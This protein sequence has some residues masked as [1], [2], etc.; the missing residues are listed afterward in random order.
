[1]KKYYFIICALFFLGCDREEITPRT[2]PQFSVAFI[3]EID[4]V[5]AEFSANVFDYGSDEIV[6]YGF[7]YGR[8]ESPRVEHSEVLKQAGKPEKT[9]TM[10][11]VHSLVIG[12]KYF[13]AAFIRTSSSVIYSKSESFMSKGSTG[14]YL[15]RIEH[16]DKLY[17]GDTLTFYGSNFSRVSSSYNIS[18]QG[19]KMNVFNLK[20]DVFQVKL[21]EMFP[22]PATDIKEFKLKVEIAGKLLELSKIF[23]FKD[24]II[25]D[26]EYLINY[27][28]TVVIR[29]KNLRSA[30]VSIHSNKT[31]LPLIKASDEE[32]VFIPKFPINSTSNSLMVNIR[33]RDILLNNKLKFKPT[34]VN[35]G[36]IFTILLG[37]TITLNGDNFNSFYPTLHRLSS[38]DGKVNFNG[39]KGDQHQTIKFNINQYLPLPRH[40]V[41]NIQTMGSM[42]NNTIE[43][44]LI[45]PALKHFEAWPFL[46]LHPWPPGD[47]MVSYKGVGL[48][49]RR[50]RIFRIDPNSKKMEFLLET[51]NDFSMNKIALAM[52]NKKIFLGQE[53]SDGGGRYYIYDP[54]MNVVVKEGFL[55][56]NSPFVAA[57]FA[58]DKYIY[59]QDIESSN[60]ENPTAHRYN[61]Q[62]GQW[63]VIGT[64]IDLSINQFRP[65]YY[66]NELYALCQNTGGNTEIKRFDQVSEKWIIVKSFPFPL[67]VNTPEVFIIEGYIYATTPTANIRISL[68]DYRLETTTNIGGVRDNSSFSIISG[69]KYYVLHP[70]EWFYEYD[71]LYFKF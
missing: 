70:D 42:A 66:Q 33:G 2:N 8:T 51:S 59:C 44:N 50:N 46:R 64:Y 6:E 45:N 61:I 67:D 20:E 24:P 40:V 23:E 37:E 69:G 19:T 12:Q 11:A 56:N 52:P 13:V 3:Q 58:T 17:F 34:S 26:E 32:I 28:D 39:L 65:Y 60:K 9:F 27:S 43:I 14:F 35:G 25:D 10:K 29:G 38:L 54:E 49:F 5:G 16:S 71:P 55:P 36:Q 68:T 1:M 21:P 31:L 53:I 47:K 15:E 63:E 22:V 4:A 48:F 7:V 62:T 57:A 41:Y 18:I 30:I